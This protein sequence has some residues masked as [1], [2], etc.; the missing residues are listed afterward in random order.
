MKFSSKTIYHA[1]SE[2]KNNQIK[3]GYQLM[4]DNLPSDMVD[5]SIVKQTNR[6][7]DPIIAVLKNSHLSD[8]KNESTIQIISNSIPKTPKP[9]IVD[10][11]RSRTTRARW[12]Y[13]IR[14]KSD[15]MEIM[16]EIYSALSRTQ[17]VDHS[18]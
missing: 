18:D 17:L 14:S 8:T 16:R 2:T 10:P 12:H 4:I 5:F 11:R 9:E 13:G 6:A 15:P 1:L 3:V 7:V